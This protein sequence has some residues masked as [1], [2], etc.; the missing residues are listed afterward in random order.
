MLSRSSKISRKR[1]IKISILQTHRKKITVMVA[2]TPKVLV[3]F[4]LSHIIHNSMDFIPR[5]RPNLTNKNLKAS[6]YQSSAKAKEG[7]TQDVMRII[8]TIKS[9]DKDEGIHT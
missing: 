3:R 2:L 6:S 5:V 4:T 9:C 7:L 1:I 8:E